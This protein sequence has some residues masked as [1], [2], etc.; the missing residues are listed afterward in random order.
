MWR[1]LKV[2][3]VDDD[4]SRRHDLKIILDFL[5]E[6]AVI[7]GC[8]DWLAVASSALDE[9]SPYV[10]VILGDCCR[11]RALDARLKE[12][13][14]WD[15]AVPVILAGEQQVISDE[16]DPYLKHMVIASLEVPPTYSKLLDTLH[17]AQ[18]YR[19][20]FELRRRQANIQRPV[21]L[22]RSLVGTSREIEVVR[23]MMGQVADKD[24]TVLITGESGTGKEVVARNLHYNSDRRDKPFVPVNCGAIPAELLESELFVMKRVPLPVLF[25][26][27][28]VALKWLRAAHCFWMK[29]VICR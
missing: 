4:E 24:V 13:Q 16:W 12:I 14:S 10:A 11:K 15:N 22:F 2:L 25:L 5:G 1:E 9:D 28:L 23:E 18:R 17:R 8:E 19:E 20:A 26:P 21:H 3:V 29:S 27:V 7:T 6:P